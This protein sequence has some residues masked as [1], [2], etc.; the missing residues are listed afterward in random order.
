MSNWEKLNFC[1]NFSR[2]KIDNLIGYLVGKIE[3]Y[4]NLG[5]S[6]EEIVKCK[7]KIKESTE[8]GK[9]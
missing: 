7:Q 3:L 5:C 4:G 6:L 9:L 1:W 8:N 2:G